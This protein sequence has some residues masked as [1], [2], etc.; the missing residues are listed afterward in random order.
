MRKKHFLY[1]FLIAV[2]FATCGNAESADMKNQSEMISG[3]WKYMLDNFAIITGYTGSEKNVTIPAMIDGH[4]V[5][6]IGM[7]VFKDSQQVTKVIISEGITTINAYAFWNSNVNLIHVPLSVVSIGG[8]AFYKGTILL[9]YEG[10]CAQQ[11]AAMNAAFGIVFVPSAEKTTFS[12]SGTCG[13]GVTWYLD[14]S[15]ELLIQ[16]NG[17]IRDYEYFPGVSAT[18]SPWAP[19]GAIIRTIRIGEGITAIGNNAFA[20][21]SSS[22]RTIII[23][24][25]LRKFGHNAFII[26]D[27][28]KQDAKP[29]EG[30]MWLEEEVA[31][32]TTKFIMKSSNSTAEGYFGDAFNWN[33]HLSC[34][35]YMK[36]AGPIGS[37]CNFEFSWTEKIPDN[38]FSGFNVETVRFPASIKEYGKSIFQFSYYLKTL[39]FDGDMP[40]RDFFGEL[41][42][43]ANYYLETPVTIFYPR[44]NPTW[45]QENILSLTT[46]NWHFIGVED[47]QE[48]SMN[49][50]HVNGNGYELTVNIDE[51][52]QYP[53]IVY[54]NDGEVYTGS[55]DWHV[56]DVDSFMNID[57]EGVLH[58][59]GIGIG[60]IEGIIEDGGSLSCHVVAK[61]N[62]N[63]LQVLYYDNDPVRAD[64]P[65]DAVR[66]QVTAPGSCIYCADGYNIYVQV[67][68]AAYVEEWEIAVE[69]SHPDI[70]IVKENRFI[71][72]VRGG[73]K[74][75]FIQALTTGEADVTF[76]ETVSGKSITRHVTV[77]PLPDSMLPTCTVNMFLGETKNF[78]SIIETLFV[79][80]DSFDLCYFAA[81]DE[82]IIQA[83]HREDQSFPVTA[84]AIG[85]TTVTIET[86]HGLTSQII[87]NVICP[88]EE[89]SFILPSSL[90]E[91]GSEAFLHTGATELILPEGVTTIGSRAFA[92][93]LLKRITIPA[94]VVNI[95]ANAFEN[96]DVTIITTKGSAAATYAL[97]HGFSCEYQ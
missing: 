31:C 73:K 75:F 11:Y 80:A 88:P 94:S 45:S 61:C 85:S 42:Y 26:F 79:P 30:N 44:S 69:S 68:P 17:A 71:D 46:A 83:K 66:L 97:E 33:E 16:G 28:K 23:P 60:H 89:T 92:D 65:V 36:T 1:I 55:V 51:T 76:T 93:S 50:S 54:Q 87:I 58:F 57:E 10:N 47:E 35:V 32:E 96:C 77:P 74:H 40:S 9:G 20:M 4:A 53:L 91:I 72:E 70:V 21:Y 49:A 41:A 15:G 18:S 8:N 7:D 5:K 14:E 25:S 84:I 59:T 34:C 29:T 24:Q 39:I 43:H 3:D 90:T 19:Y 22:V 67:E 95:A 86:N 62:A 38:A 56:D 81:F 63:A 48:Y 2:I 13:D 82:S 64:T 78:D 6:T 52:A 12:A 37:G 27:N